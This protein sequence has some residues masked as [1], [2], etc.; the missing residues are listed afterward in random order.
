MAAA[1]TAAVL[2]LVV[3]SAPALAQDCA[4]AGM[5]RVSGLKPDNVSGILLAFCTLAGLVATALLAGAWRGPARPGFLDAWAGYAAL[6]A[7]TAGI[8]ALD[9]LVPGV[10]PFAVRITATNALLLFGSGL[11][12]AGARR[13]R[14][15]RAR[16]WLVALPPL[17]WLAASGLVPGFHESLLPR[18]L[19]A[20][21]LYVL[22]HAAAAFE[23]LRR[24]RGG[25]A[26]RI[27]RALAI[28]TALT[29]AAHLARIGLVVAGMEALAFNLIAIASASLLLVIG[30]GG[31]ALAGE[32]SARREAMALQ[33]ARAEVE[34]LH[35][36][37][38]AI[39]FLHQVDPDGGSRRVYHGGDFE[40]V[41]GWPEPA[42]ARQNS[43]AGFDRPRRAP[44]EGCHARDALRH[45]SA[46]HEWRMRQP[47]G[48]LHLDAGPICAGC[49]SGRMAAARW[50]ATA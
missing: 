11:L 45:G 22:L 36:G 31:V 40:A 16:A 28:L 17:L 48:V 44:P 21:P 6:G 29:G 7:A 14:G 38:P 2:S 15:A 9:R 26:P 30:V 37:L 8:L 19:I 12:W 23:C 4:A 25:G 46:V 1:G 33:A 34:R 3:A 27:L 43:L 41:L 42:L 24:H 50:S 35:A 49:R 10:A 18:I 47:D 39:V 5:G 32:L 20:A 13:L